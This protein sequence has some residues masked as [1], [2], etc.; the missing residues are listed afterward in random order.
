MSSPTPSA[1]STAAPTLPAVP[2][3]W[4]PAFT[5]ADDAKLRESLKRCSPGTYEA[6]SNF[7]RSGNAEHLPVLLY[8][9]IERFVERERRTLLNP[10]RDDLRLVED[11]GLDS[12]TLME[13]VL[14]AEEVLPISINNEDLCELRTLG[15]VKRQVTALLQ[16]VATGTAPASSAIPS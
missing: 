15:D 10:A 7:R 8:G 11:L 12:L 4:L 13:I 16:S 14:L 2:P 5:E 9:I 3:A 6:A 1:P